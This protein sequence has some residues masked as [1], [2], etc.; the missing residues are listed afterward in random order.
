MPPNP[1]T[2]VEHGDIRER[3][4]NIDATLAAQHAT[5]K[6]MAASIEENSKFRL[7]F[8]AI[9]SAIMVAATL[10]GTVGG[11]AWARKTLAAEYIRKDTLPVEVIVR[12]QNKRVE[13]SAP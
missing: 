11:W 12:E 3:L 9:V 6:L 5:L 1:A 8:V 4:G 13:I 7:K 2:C 10:M